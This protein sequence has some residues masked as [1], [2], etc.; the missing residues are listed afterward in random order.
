MGL[1]DLAGGQAP[2]A[3]GAPQTAGIFGSMVDASSPAGAPSGA[4]A[5]ASLKMA[6]QLA[7]NPT[8]EMGAQIVAQMRQAG[9]PEADQIEQYLAHVGANPQAIRSAAQQVIQALSQ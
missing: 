2:A 5:Q 7:Q 4:S 6:Q 3:Q 1:L 8:P 9:M